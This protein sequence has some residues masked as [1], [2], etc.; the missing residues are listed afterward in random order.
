M[1]DFQNYM[2]ATQTAIFTVFDLLRYDVKNDR[3]ILSCARCGIKRS[4]WHANIAEWTHCPK[5]HVPIIKNYL[6]Q[7]KAYKGGRNAKEM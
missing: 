7:F 5:C 1:N 2:D 3:V 4:D 6:L